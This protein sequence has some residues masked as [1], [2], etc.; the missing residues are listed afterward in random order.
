MPSGVC[1]AFVKRL[2][3][4]GVMFI[5]PAAVAA[6]P[7]T[8]AF[9]RT[10]FPPGSIVIVNRERS[11]Y[12]VGADGGALRY[13][14]AIG[15]ADEQ[16]VGREVVTDKKVNP[17][18]IEP[19]DDGEGTVIEGGE[20]NNP[21]GIRALYLGKTLWRIHGT[22]SPRLIGKAVSNGC[23]RM[24]NSDVVDLYDRVGVGT[25]VFVVRSLKQRRPA[26]PG[27]KLSDD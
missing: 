8:V 15:V 4:A 14:V 17:R 9:S 27:R 23:I 19:D 6:A 1:C 7:E 20:P 25:E 16:W 10:D 22:I 3:I 13:P 12:L 21:L 2:A 5:L 11:L 18:W 24:H 26:E